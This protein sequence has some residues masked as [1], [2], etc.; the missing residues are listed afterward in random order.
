MDKKRPAS[1]SEFLSALGLALHEWQ[2]VEMALCS[3]LATTMRTPDAR[4]A[5]EMFYA[6]Q[7]FRDKLAM[8]DAAFRFTFWRHPKLLPAWKKL[9]DAIRKRSSRR[10][11]IVHA[12]THEEHVGDGDIS[13]RLG[14]HMRLS[15]I[16][17]AEAEPQEAFIDAKQLIEAAAS[18]NTL[19]RRIRAFDEQV[20]ALLALRL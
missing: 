17:A 19:A 5:A 16:V 4:L 3:L 2:L 18:F 15:E 10:N 7:N 14:P 9:M 8:V 1:R 12:H 6:V 20:R 13:Y 11:A